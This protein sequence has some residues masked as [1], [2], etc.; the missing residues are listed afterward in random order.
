MNRRA[1]I[2]GGVLVLLVL[3]AILTRGFG[4]F[5]ADGRALTLYGNVDV[6]Q[7]DLAFRVP[8][9]IEA[10]AVEEGAKVKAGQMLAEL[11]K[12][13]LRDTLAA[14][15]AQLGVAGA[16]LAKVR[17][18]NRPQEIAQAQARFAE[19][20]AALA[21]AKED[22]DRRAELVKTG[23]V[24]QQVYDATQARY[25]AAQAQAKAAEEALSLAR[26]GARAEDREAIAAQAEA[27]RAQRDSAQ[28][29]MADATLK[30][31]NAGTILT[32]ARE[33]GAIVQPGET[34]LTLTIDRPM[35]IRAYVGGNDLSRLSPGMKV[36]VRAD[37]NDRRYEGTI[38]H[39]SPTAEFTPKT[40]QTEDLRTDLVYRV[41]I[42]VNNPDDALRQGQP[43][44]IDVTDA[45][46]AGRD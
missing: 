8:G 33:P 20:Q 21:N 43:V 28:T 34:V 7:V 10:I 42:L 19:A 18:G 25:R 22:H 4:L 14:A 46:P 31:P 40:V 37:G 2:G 16:E 6:R 3:G 38:A 15:E 35:R 44:T 9:R 30:A 11:D 29:N 24:S 13:P 26:T 39:I 17:A 5:G 45:R 32:R 1:L 41:R 36:T 27:A 12:R 23:A